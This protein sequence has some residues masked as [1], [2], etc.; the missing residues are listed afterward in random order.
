MNSAATPSASRRSVLQVAGLG[1]AAALTGCTLSDG[2]TSARR[3]T[4]PPAPTGGQ[5]VDADVVL[6]TR[7]IADEEVLLDYCRDLVG[8]H[9]T[10]VELV[11]PVQAR[12]RDHVGALRAALTRADP[13]PA[14]RPPGRVP[15]KARVAVTTLT[16]LASGAEQERFADCLAAESGLLARLLASISASHAVTVELTRTRQ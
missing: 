3:T 6:L 8:A 15:G 16:Q 10:L 1:I 2:S 11:R 14:Q 5:P 4:T 9:P 12:Q 7:A 13:R